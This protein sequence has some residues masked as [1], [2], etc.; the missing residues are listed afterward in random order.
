M[1]GFQH[2]QIY[3]NVQPTLMMILKMMSSDPYMSTLLYSK[4]Q[5]LCL[6]TM[7]DFTQAST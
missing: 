2:L 5:Y 3:N 7:N 4:R 1:V 6:Y